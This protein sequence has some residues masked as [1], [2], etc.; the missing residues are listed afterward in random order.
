MS[1]FLADEALIQD[2]AGQLAQAVRGLP[3]AEQTQIVQ[4]AIMA[5]TLQAA[6]ARMRGP[7]SPNGSWRNAPNGAGT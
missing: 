7:E 6:D 1:E 3:P 5:A 4:R 2:A